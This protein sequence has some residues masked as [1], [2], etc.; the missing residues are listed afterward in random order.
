[1][2]KSFI[3]ASL[4]FLSTVSMANSWVNL[5]STCQKRVSLFGL[6]T[7][8]SGHITQGEYDDF[9]RPTGNTRQ[10]PCTADGNWDWFW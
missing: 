7:I 9:G 8:W 2:K 4:L 10:V 6:V 5:G 3:L 1:M